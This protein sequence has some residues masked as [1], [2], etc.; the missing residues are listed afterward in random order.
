MPRPIGFSWFEYFLKKILLGHAL[1]TWSY[2][3]IFFFF[4]KCYSNLL[5]TLINVDG[6]LPLNI[7]GRLIK[8]KPW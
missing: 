5:N 1:N 7:C 4:F 6:G 3:L 8:D 2:L